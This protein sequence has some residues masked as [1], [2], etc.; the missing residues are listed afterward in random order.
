MHHVPRTFH[1]CTDLVNHNFFFMSL[2][3]YVQEVGRAVG[4][5]NSQKLRKLLTI[6]PGPKEGA[7]RAGF[8]DPSDVDLYQAPEKFKPVIRA[9]LK[10]MRLIY[11]ANDINSSFYDL[12]ELMVHLNRAAETQNNWICPAL[13]NGSNELISVYQV[14]SKTKKDDEDALEL[15]AN[16]INKLFKICLTDKT[17]DMAVSKK[18]SIH[19]FLAAL[20]KIYFKLNR[21]E[22]AKSMEKALIGTGLAVPTIVHSPVKYR[23]HIVTYL[24]FSA[25]LSLD[26]GDFAFAET[27]LATAMDFLSCYQK[28]QNVQKQAEKI[29]ILLIPIKLH[30]SGQ[31]LPQKVWDRFPSLQFMYRDNLFTAIHSGNLRMFDD[32]VEKFQ[33]ILLKRHIFLLVLHLK[34]ACYLRLVR[35]TCSIFAELN[36]ASPHIVPFSAFQL[37]FDYSASK[38]GNVSEKTTPEAVECILANLIAARKIKGYMS[39]G[40]RCIVLLKTE[41]FPKVS[42]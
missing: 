32:C 24:Y 42:T 21:L 25:L 7:L 28:P 11:V 16:T 37:A 40:N 20:I 10:L 4:S 30:N 29:L 41:A 5:E 38:S 36:P 34:D 33:T 31:T 8:Q 2:Y 9:Y 27:K 35:R 12:K 18:L 26:E 23:M 1:R 22:L 13:I 3:E 39:H 17:M 19:F 6:N 15:V 14:R